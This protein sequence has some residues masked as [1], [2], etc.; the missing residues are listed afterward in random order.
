[1]ASVYTRSAELN[2]ERDEFH[3][4]ARRLAALLE[5]KSNK[6]DAFRAKCTCGVGKNY[7]LAQNAPYMANPAVCTLFLLD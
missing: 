4:E 3:R 2:T 5:W 6:L 1:M 7:F